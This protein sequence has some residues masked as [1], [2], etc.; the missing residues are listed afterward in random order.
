M[1]II[2]HTASFLSGALL[3]I[4][5]LACGGS[6]SHDS[7]DDGLLL[8]STQCDTGASITPTSVRVHNGD[9][10]V[11]N[12]SLQGGYSIQTIYCTSGGTLIG[13]QFTMGQVQAADNVHVVTQGRYVGA[14]VVTNADAQVAAEP[15]SSDTARVV[16]RAL[17][18]TAQV[19]AQQFAT[20]TLDAV[21][22]IDQ[23]NA[24]LCLRAMVGDRAL[25]LPLAQT[26]LF[27]H[28]V[29][30]PFCEVTKISDGEQ[31]PRILV[32][33]I[34]EEESTR[35]LGKCFVAVHQ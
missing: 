27:V 22:E 15:A 1:R 7:G 14:A 12:I 31:L 20:S 10:P 13:T 29:H 35:V 33:D 32:F 26:S 19:E 11:F 30:V 16:V 28:E 23:E 9:R 2:R 25:T 4:G 3:L 24:K 6:H 18:A 8:V 34:V 5:L 21:V 17:N